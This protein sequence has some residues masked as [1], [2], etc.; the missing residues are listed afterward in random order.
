MSTWCPAIQIYISKEKLTFIKETLD[1][2]TFAFQ[3]AA[4]HLSWE[5]D[6]KSK[7]YCRLRSTLGFDVSIN[8]KLV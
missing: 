4:V 3:C 6:L 8:C 7:S 2:L 5:V 1:E